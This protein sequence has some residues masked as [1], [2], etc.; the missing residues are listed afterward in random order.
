MKILNTGLMAT[1]L[2]LPMVVG[3]SKQMSA[4]MYGVSLMMLANFVPSIISGVAALHAFTGASLAATASLTILTGGLFAIAAIAGFLIFDSLLGDKFKSDLLD[5]ESLND[6]L[7]TTQVLL[8]DLSGAAGKEVVMEGYYDEATFNMLKQDAEL[9]DEVLGDL[10]NRIKLITEDLTRAKTAGDTEMAAG[11]E[12]TKKHL[13]DVQAQVLA[14]DKAQTIVSKG[15]YEIAD[16][17][18]DVAVK[19][20]SHGVIGDLF[21]DGEYQ[22]VGKKNGESFTKGFGKGADGK[23]AA[24]AYA[25]ELKA[26]GEG[27]SEITQEFNMEY[28]ANLLKVQEDA[29]EQIIEGEKRLYNALTQEQNNFANAREELFFG[30]RQNFTGAIY[31]QVVQGGVESLLHKTEIVQTN[32][33]NGYNT[34]QMVARV[35][36]GVLDELRAQ[37]VMTA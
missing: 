20:K 37:G 7:N 13:E 10:N 18:S 15:A 33:F 1:T 32:V 34:E 6:S 23:R 30:Q 4:M 26:S 9:T 36:R 11:L 27:M 12:Q 8:S 17:Y 35:S 22:V 16:A 3:E 2:I 29:N 19:Q 21:M 28:Y 24:E 5:I 31:K 25:A 14:I